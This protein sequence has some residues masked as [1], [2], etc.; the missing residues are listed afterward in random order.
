V[1][2]YGDR[3]EEKEERKMRTNDKR[4]TIDVYRTGRRRDVTATALFL[5]E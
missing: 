1:R 5:C 2:S 4:Q 3:K